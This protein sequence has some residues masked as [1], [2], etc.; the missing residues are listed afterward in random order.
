MVKKIASGI[1]FIRLQ[2]REDVDLWSECVVSGTLAK[3]DY[4]KSR[5]FHRANQACELIN[6]F[7][8][9]IFAC[10]LQSKWLL[11][12][13]DKTVHYKNCIII[14]IIPFYYHLC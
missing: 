8:L 1:S 9:S 13:F 4:L 6:N 5:G 14:I 2:L 3:L 7:D 11:S 12:Q 10:F